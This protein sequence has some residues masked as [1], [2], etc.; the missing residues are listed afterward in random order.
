MRQVYDGFLEEFMMQSKVSAVT[1]LLALA[2]AAAAV[3]AQTPSQPQATPAGGMSP[4]GGMDKMSGM[5]MKG[6]K[7]DA[8]KPPLPTGPLK[9]I[10]E[11]KSAEWTPATLAALPH[12]T[13]T[14]FSAHAKANLTYSGVPLTDLLTKLG[15][16]N[17]EHG[18][19]LKLYLVAQGSDGYKVVFSLGEVTPIFNN[20]TVIVADSL[21]GKPIAGEGSLQLVNSGDKV[22]SRWVRNPVSIKVLS[23]E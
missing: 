5:D 4:M 17:G 21:E 19:T 23:V 1:I 13:V 14:F 16:P 18:K 7:M 10:Y 9:I 6:M 2:V 15:V 3:Q 20:S 22:Q 11:D 8:A 12:K